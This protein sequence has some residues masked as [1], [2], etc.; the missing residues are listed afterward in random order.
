MRATGAQLRSVHLVLDALSETREE[1]MTG[2]QNDA[3]IMVI[4]CGNRYAG[5]DAA[6]IIVVEA[7]SKAA[8]E[9]LCLRMMHDLG[10]GFL[11][12]AGKQASIVMIVDAIRSG[13]AIGTVCFLKLPS[14]SVVPRNVGGISTHSLGLETEIDLASRCGNCPKMFLV[15]IEI[16]HQCTGQYLS[17][18][19]SAAIEKVVTGFTD[20]C[21]R[22]R[23]QSRA[24]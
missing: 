6:G 12:E 22:A 4:G 15:G 14:E 1:L 10:P 5:D 18:A 20:F 23:S 13:A 8:P 19:V 2:L 3:T 9:G 7:L 16:S 11:C 21:G 17:P 24:Q